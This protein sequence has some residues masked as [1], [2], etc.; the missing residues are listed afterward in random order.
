M[1]HK[2]FSRKG[3]QAKSEKKR[4]SGRANLEKARIALL[5]KR[6]NA[7]AAKTPSDSRADQRGVSVDMTA[8]MQTRPRA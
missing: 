5:E 2:Q 8:S 7:N 4:Q 3:G 6:Q 1:D